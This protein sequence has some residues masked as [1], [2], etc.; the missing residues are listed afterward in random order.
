MTTEAVTV[1]SLLAMAN[2]IKPIGLDLEVDW[3]LV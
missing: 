2:S 3:S 1:R